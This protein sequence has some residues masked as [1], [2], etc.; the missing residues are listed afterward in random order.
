MR[1]RVGGRQQLRHW[2][3]GTSRRGGCVRDRGAAPEAPGAP[4]AQV[5]SRGWRGGRA[6][7]VVRRG[8]SLPEVRGRLCGGDPDSARR[9]AVEARTGA[10]NQFKSLLVTAPEQ[11]TTPLWVF[12][13]LR[14]STPALDGAV[15][16]PQGALHR[17]GSAQLRT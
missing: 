14:L 16:F 8:H 7:G 11:I 9:C 13:P 6:C 1:C 10:L 12:A 2:P 5:R 4:R 17:G 15:S 3:G